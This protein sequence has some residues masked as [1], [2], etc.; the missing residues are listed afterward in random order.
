MGNLKD[1]SMSDPLL[2]TSKLFIDPAISKGYISSKD[3]GNRLAKKLQAIPP[4][5]VDG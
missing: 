4:V 1:F 2:L 3:Y 5:K